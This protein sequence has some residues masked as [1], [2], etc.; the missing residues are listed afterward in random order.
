MNKLSRRISTLLLAV[1]V[2]ASITIPTY[3]ENYFDAKLTRIESLM[4]QAKAKGINTDYEQ[5]A[6][7]TVKRTQSKLLNDEANGKDTQ[8]VAYNKAKMD[9]ML[10]EAISNLEEYINGTKKAKKVS[11]PSMGNVEVFGSSLKSGGKD[12]KSVV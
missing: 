10:D 2:C 6:Y 7:S 1:S 9:N 12:R 8:V 5:V 3:A 4:A 11:L